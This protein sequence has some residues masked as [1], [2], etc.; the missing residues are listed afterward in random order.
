MNVAPMFQQ[1]TVG[2]GP[3]RAAYN[4]PIPRAS[5]DQIESSAAL[6][7]QISSNLDVVRKTLLVPDTEHRLNVP[8]S[9]YSPQKSPT[10]PAIVPPPAPMKQD[11]PCH[12]MPNPSPTTAPSRAAPPPPAKAQLGTVESVKPRRRLVKDIQ[13]EDL[14]ETPWQDY[15]LPQELEILQANLPDEIQSIIRESLDEQRAI[16]LSRLHEPAI[17]VRKTVTVSN[18]QRENAGGMVAESSAMAASRHA[19]ST[20]PTTSSSTLQTESL[21]LSLDSTTSLGSSNVGIDRLKPA[22][23]PDDHNSRSSGENQRSDVQI[24]S[25]KLQKSREKLSRAH[26]VFKMLRRTKDAAPTAAPEPETDECISCFDDIPIE[27]AIGVPCR[28]KYC[29]PC[30]SQLI[31]TALQNEDHFPPKCCLQE[32]PRGVLRKHL[33]PNELSSFDS[34]ALEYSVAIGSRYYCA[35]PE[36]AKWIDTKKT[37]THNGAL[38]CPHCN[39]SMCTVCRGPEHPAGQDCPQDFG[40]DATLQQAE[41]AGWRRCYSCRALVELNTGCRHI[42]C[43]CRAE[44][45][46]TCGARWRTCACTEEDQARRAR[47]IRQNLEKLDAEARAEEEEIRL[48]IAAVEEA[49]RRA[50]EERMEQERR[51]EEERAEEARRLTEKEFRRVEGIVQHFNHMREILEKVRLYQDGALYQRH[52][53]EIEDLNKKEDELAALESLSEEQ[54]A[55]ESKRAEIVANT[56]AKMQELKK[57]HAAELVQTR[58]RHRRDE[59]DFLLQLTAEASSLSDDAPDGGTAVDAATKHEALLSAQEL[60]RSTLRA[61]Q[62]RAMATAQKRGRF[63]LHAFEEEDGHRRR[64]LEA[65]RAVRVR[66]LEQGVREVRRR[67]WAEGRWGRVVGEVRVEMLGEDER[68]MVLTGTEAPPPEGEVGM[69]KGKM[70]G[71]FQEGDGEGK[72]EGCVLT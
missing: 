12:E 54:Q 22:A 64:D 52:E 49:E 5:A 26:G 29:A 34:K 23:Y 21:K 6:K 67:Q 35:R 9:R 63:H 30:F 60:E 72:G 55:A 24:A 13:L 59:D 19:N 43:K 8:R 56:D 3:L 11:R 37:R 4:P 25:R 1:A 7:Q 69:G 36:C 66:E 33:P 46:Y 41:R 50:E 44:F 45:C 31:A 32:I 47:E 15:D 10:A 40:L 53:Y 14:E 58:S 27:E 20:L 17:V 2:Q 16:R 48:A 18:P 68:R 42:T 71:S 61:M 39:N 28:H 65:A 62:A 38:V 70:P 51:V 57:K